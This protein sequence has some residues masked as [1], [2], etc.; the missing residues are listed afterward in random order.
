[1]V[2]PTLSK[3]IL[4]LVPVVAAPTGGN[5]AVMGESNRLAIVI[6]PIVVPLASISVTVPTYLILLSHGIQGE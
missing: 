6:C 3:T 2:V 4:T 5:I 1:L